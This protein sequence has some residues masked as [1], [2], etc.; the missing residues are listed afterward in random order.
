MEELLK[1][2]DRI[3][4]QQDSMLATITRLCEIN[5]GTLNL[6]GVE[7]VTHSLSNFSNRL[8]VTCN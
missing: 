6:E 1:H 2:V 3:N 7:K 8:A 5:S 4:D